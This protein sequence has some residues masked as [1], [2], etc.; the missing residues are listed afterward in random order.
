MQ[1]D[2]VT[3]L[4]CV[5]STCLL[6][7]QA[8]QQACISSFAACPVACERAIMSTGVKGQPHL[9]KSISVKLLFPQCRQRMCWHLDLFKSLVYYM[10]YV[11]ACMGTFQA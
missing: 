1:L 8:T 11:S 9:P 2:F 3:E 6:F 7:R 4:I 5:V 10:E